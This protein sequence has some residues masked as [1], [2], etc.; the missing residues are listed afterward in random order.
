[1]PFISQSN[2]LQ[3]LGWA[4]INSLWQ[5]ALLWIVY[6]FFVLVFKPGSSLKAKSAFITL[7]AGTVWFFISFFIA[8]NSPHT[9]TSVFS[10][11]GINYTFNDSI[12][13][14]LPFASVIYLLL[15]SIPAI[16]FII[17]RITGIDNNTK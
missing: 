10:A 5:M 3:A 9:A 1:M 13:A 15:L 11:G 7:V 12:S 8:F 17:N 14:I 6:K 2:F 16:R 4:V